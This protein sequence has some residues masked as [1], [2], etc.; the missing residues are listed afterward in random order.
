MKRKNSGE[1]DALYT[2][3]GPKSNSHIVWSSDEKWLSTAEIIRYF[4]VSERT[5]LRWRNN[6]DLPFT[7][8][9]GT[10]LYPFNL[11]NRILLNKL[12]PAYIN[13]DVDFT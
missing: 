8:L 12:Q 2:T 7:R 11:V 3:H 4:N 5:L 1:A 9:G 10:V 13:N 6:G